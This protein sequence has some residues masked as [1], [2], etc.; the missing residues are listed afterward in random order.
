MMPAPSGGNYRGS[1]NCCVAEPLVENSSSTEL[2]NWEVLIRAIVAE[3][4]EFRALNKSELAARVLAIGG[5]Q[6]ADQ[7]ES[8]N[9]RARLALR[10]AARIAENS[11]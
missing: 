6:G 4:T 10:L 11:D 8:E 7:P 2:D 5:Y 3:A 1:M 9:D